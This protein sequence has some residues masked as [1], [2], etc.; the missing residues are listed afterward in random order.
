[1]HPTTIRV[2]KPARSAF[3]V[4]IDVGDARLA[5]LSVLSASAS[6]QQAVSVVEL[7]R[8]LSPEQMRAL[9]EM[10]AAAVAHYSI[11]V[12]VHV[13]A[14]AALTAARP[15]LHGDAIVPGLVAAAQL[16]LLT[17]HRKRYGFAR[18]FCRG[19]CV[20]DL[21]C[22]AGY[23]ARMLALAAGQV[24]AADFDEQAIR[25]AAWRFVRHNLS[26]L[27]AD[28]TH[29]PL[30]DAVVDVV[31]SCETI[32]H[33][34]PEQMAPFLGEF[35]RVLAPG[36]VLIL[37]TPNV[38]GPLDQQWG[39]VNLT[40][41]H[42]RGH[43]VGFSSAALRAWL[44]RFFPHVAILYQGSQAPQA[45]PVPQL[46]LWTEPPAWWETL[47]AVA[48]DAPLDAVSFQLQSLPLDL[49]EA[50]EVER[51]LAHPDVAVVHATLEKRGVSCYASFALAHARGGDLP[52]AYALLDYVRVAGLGSERPTLAFPPEWASAE[53]WA[54]ELASIV[55]DGFARGDWPEQILSLALPSALANAAP[56]SGA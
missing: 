25:E 34:R 56:V 50:A 48:S 41:A 35:Q 43:Q 11:A 15:T 7:S 3:R 52:P 49:Y 27:R 32:E 54:D 26:H 47:V 10:A 39:L 53:Q 14:P 28:G 20:L 6:G 45:D 51:F 36:G 12:D 9:A 5:T 44:E 22:G 19:K 2:G 29:A 21:A 24:L 4:V 42:Q 8:P 31:V 13:E 33:V 46:E 1:M 55:A 40:G 18:Q 16:P 23:G 30:R 38:D 17:A 37:S